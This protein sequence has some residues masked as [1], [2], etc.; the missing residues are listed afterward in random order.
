MNDRE[1]A[2]DAGQDTHS[3]A[4]DA[5]QT[6]AAPEATPEAAPDPAASDELEHLHARIAGLEDELGKTK[7][8][9]MRAAAETENIRRRSAREREDI[10]RYAAADLLK[11]V[12]GVA[13]NLRRAIDAVPAEQR[14]A[15]QQLAT[16]LEGVEA[17]ERQLLQSFEKHG[18]KRVDALGKPFD[19][20]FH[21]AM[22]EVED[23]ESPAGTVV[24]EMVPGYVLHDRLLR[25][26]MVG[27]AK[28]GPAQAAANDSGQDPA[29]SSGDPYGGGAGRGDPK[30]DTNA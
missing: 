15:D 12:L 29:S 16:V 26:A 25:P 18:V 19:H 30:F 9:Y 27:V 10:Q 3:D 20:R 14:A 28:G 21:E 8:A 11:D 2:P 7:D 5:P 23:P 22:F 6:Q 13:D 4:T 1:K 17:T 24:Q